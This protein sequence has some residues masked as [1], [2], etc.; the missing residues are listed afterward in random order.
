M[1][2]VM[3]ASDGCDTAWVGFWFVVGCVT[4]VPSESTHVMNNWVSGKEKINKSITTKPG[5]EGDAR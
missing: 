4:G 1:P 5:G 3:S 2:G